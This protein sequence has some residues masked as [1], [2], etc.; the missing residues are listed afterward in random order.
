MWIKNHIVGLIVLVLSAYVYAIKEKKEKTDKE[1]IYVYLYKK[2]LP[3]VVEY[4]DVFNSF[5]ADLKKD[6]VSMK[7]NPEIH[8]YVFRKLGANI[9]IFEH[10]SSHKQT[11]ADFK[12]LMEELTHF[13]TKRICE[14]SEKNRESGIDTELL[15]QIQWKVFAMAIGYKKD[16]NS[17]WRTV[18]NICQLKNVMSDQQDLFSTLD[19][20]SS[21]DFVDLLLFS[22]FLCRESKKTQYTRQ[23]IENNFFFTTCVPV[24]IAYQKNIKTGKKKLEILADFEK[25]V[26]KVLVS[27]NLNKR[28]TLHPLSYILQDEEYWKEI[29]ISKNMVGSPIIALDEFEDTI[30]VLYSSFA[31]SGDSLSLVEKLLLQ[32]YPLMNIYPEKTL[33]KRTFYPICINSTRLTAKTPVKDKRNNVIE[34]PGAPESPNRYIEKP[35]DSIVFSISDPKRKNFSYFSFKNDSKQFQA[36]QKLFNATEIHIEVSHVNE[37]DLP[38]LYKFCYL[39]ENIPIKSL[40]HT[41]TFYSPSKSVQ[42]AFFLSNISYNTSKEEKLSK[43]KT[44]LLN[45]EIYTSEKSLKETENTIVSLNIKYVQSEKEKRSFTI[46]S[47]IGR[48]ILAIGGM[49]SLA[50]GIY[51]S[52][53][54]PIL[55]IFVIPVVFPIVIIVLAIISFISSYE[56]KADK[57]IMIIFNVITL[58]FMILAIIIMTILMVQ[59][60]FLILPLEFSSYFLL[61]LSSVLSV[62]AFIA[63]IWAHIAYKRQWITQK[64]ISYLIYFFY[65]ISGAVAVLIGYLILSYTT[66]STVFS[67]MQICL[68]VFMGVVFFCGAMLEFLDRNS[69]EFRKASVRRN[70]RIFRFV[71]A[72][73]VVL[74]ALAVIALLYHYKTLNILQAGDSIDIRQ[75]FGI[76]TLKDGYYWY[77]TSPDIM[78][79]SIA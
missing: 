51:I 13:I 21:K 50:S 61:I 55:S 10:I 28:Q 33:P 27:R 38:Y 14:L 71:V 29:K 52:Y 1:D 65:G 26:K 34:D 20:Q 23:E 40:K 11:D 72:T 17:L 32:L 76:E 75:H 19:I 73:L 67:I 47:G 79:P 56:K 58:I 37:N 42:D 64:G 30:N 5:S 57:L 45:A 49:S 63:T 66:E 78:P 35:I 74:S 4:V 48:F 36:I 69:F 15:S 68:P 41:I 18:N 31:K 62:A 46:P 59:R 44:S 43:L 70:R 54:F 7:S 3:L 53:I 6:I 77:T 12:K 60:D 2:K 16:Q 25:L 22:A 8:Q 9:S 24:F 39:M